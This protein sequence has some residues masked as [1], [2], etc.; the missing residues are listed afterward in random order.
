M[1]VHS[2]FLTTH[3]QH[4]FLRVLIYNS[5]MRPI[6][7]TFTLTCSLTMYHQYFCQIRSKYCIYKGCVWLQIHC[8][9]SPT[10]LHKQSPCFLTRYLKSETAG[11]RSVS[12]RM[13]IRV[14]SCVGTGPWVV[15]VRVGEG[16][17][18]GE[19]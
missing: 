13:D 12:L 5:G 17:C 14:V 7:L 3:I 10:A 9:Q 19:F 8:I 16:V 1:F 6:Q 18:A 2:K 4:F 11:C 15:G